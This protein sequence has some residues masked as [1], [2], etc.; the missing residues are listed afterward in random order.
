MEK[1]PFAHIDH[2]QNRLRGNAHPG[3]NL[4]QAVGRLYLRQ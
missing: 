3:L 1:E 4:P 2:L